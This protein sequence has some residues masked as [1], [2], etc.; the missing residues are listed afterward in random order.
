MLINEQFKKLILKTKRIPDILSVIP[1][2]KEFELNGENLIAVP[3]KI[4]ESLVLKNLGFKKT[5]APILSY[6]DFPARFKAMRLQRKTA[7]FLTMNKRALCLNAPGTGKSVSTLWA[8]D[9]LLECGIAKKILIVAPL[10]TVKVVWGKELKH[11]FSHRSFQLII[12][13][14]EQK[15]RALAV[16]GTQFYV[17]NHDG[18]TT[19]QKDLPIFDVVIYDE[20][21]ALKNPNS[22]R[23][24]VFFRWINTYNPWLWLLTGTPI[25]Q[26]PVDAWTLARLVNNPHVPRSFTA[27]RELV[28]NRVSTFKW[29]AKPN[30]LETCMQVLQ[31]SIRH[32]LDE[33]KELP[34][35]VFLNHECPMS[36]NQH[37]SYKEM[38]EQAVLLAHDVS[39]PNAAV[40]MQK[41]LQICCG[42]VYGA[43]GERFALDFTERY[44]VLVDVIEE[45]G[46]KVI[47]FVP[48]RGVQDALYDLL[49]KRYKVSMVH[50][51][52]V[53][54]VRNNIFDDFQ[55]PNSPT[56]I[57]L[58]HPKVAAHG[59]TLTSAKDIIWFAPIYSLEMYEQANARIRRLT[60]GG[61]TRVHHLFSTALEK[62]LYSRL[63][64][65]KQILTDFLGLINGIND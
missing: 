60:T 54:A 3:H 43:G 33:F 29:V 55:D 42:C 7:A 51:Q 20:A 10:S 32:S 58:A 22:N 18:F 28:M 64:Y 1:H 44:N 48:F 52:V 2:A 27:F 41:L 37:K 62:E 8:A 47:I 25:S 19:I 24:K 16:K 31:P 36:A 11:H 23:F 6:Y 5:P 30:A 65:K 46:G 14:R 9:Y 56:Q 12:G 49:A 40:V 39:A 45:I 35:T 15:L 17:T 59:L 34:E 50:G 61:K 38:R 63:M 57:L 13:S 4:E 53:G 21:T 26:S